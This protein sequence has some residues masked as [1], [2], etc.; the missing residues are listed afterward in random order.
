[1]LNRAFRSLRFAGLFAL[2]QVPIPPLP[3]GNVPALT[4]GNPADI[5][6]TVAPQD[7]RTA[8]QLGEPVRLQ[9]RFRANAAGRY[10]FAPVSCVRPAHSPYLPIYDR[11][12]AEPSGAAE[13]LAAPDFRE[14]RSGVRTLPPEPIP[15][16][17]ETVTAECLLNDWAL[18]QK[19]GHFRITAESVRVLAVGAPP[20]IAMPLKSEA[21]E[22][23]ILPLD[24]NAARTRLQQA[25]AVLERQYSGASVEN[26]EWA[27]AVDIV[28]FSQLPEAVPVLV[29]L[30]NQ[31]ADQTVINGLWVSPYKAAIF[32]EMEKNFEAP[33]FAVSSRWVFLMAQLDGALQN[34]PAPQD[35]LKELY[36][37][38]FGKLAAIV[39]RKQGPARLASL[40]TLISEGPVY[41][42][43]VATQPFLNTIYQTFPGLPP[44]FQ[45]M[46]LT[47]R[48]SFVAS[49][50]IAPFV[51]SW[52]TSNIAARDLA[53]LRLQ[54]LDPAEAR[55]IALDRIRRGD[56]VRNVS[57]GPR[58]YGTE[59]L[60]GL[61][62]TALPELDAPLA[63]AY[64]SG[65]PVAEL[66]ARYASAAV[67]PR[68]RAAFERGPAGPWQ[69]CGVNTGL[70]PIMVYFFRVDPTYADR[71][72]AE[73]RRSAPWPCP[74][75]S[76]MVASAGLEQAA[77]RDLSDPDESLRQGA[78]AVLRNSS[79]GNGKRALREA[80]GRSASLPSENGKLHP[81]S[82][83]A[84]ALTS[85]SGW[86][87]SPE[88]FG[89]LLAMCSRDECR[90]IISGRRQMVTAPVQIEARI[91]DLETI[92]VG[93]FPISMNNFERKLRQF[94][95]GTEFRLS[96]E[97]RQASALWSGDLW[98][99]RLRQ[100]IEAAGMKVVQEP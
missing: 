1:M 40:A 90:Q 61:S 50:A 74:L 46:I 29:R 15:L 89:Q 37:K 17:T 39:D 62:D 12:L 5:T 95:A 54:V 75:T 76:P 47:D 88:E 63:E 73:A 81:S 64:E 70:E 55:R 23:D 60:M 58:Q 36:G 28:R 4:F 84:D 56:F 80:L 48:W 96:P 98:E 66:I 99:K 71:L 21:L 14:S 85:A 77:I 87:L 79:A 52:A 9:L 100:T 97:A 10:R 8:F 16:G 11:I 86:V 24:T 18:I 27:A 65:K 59:A 43:L 72:L 68:I 32:A 45:T 94:P 44:W 38:Y 35:R 78:V 49:P 33:D 20:G 31:R 30:L 42:G 6:F 57:A 2:F 67:F 83:L 69:V 92:R 19:P 82:I 7:G 22:I 53:L 91:E 26:S 3:S 41:G 51:R 34:P 93:P 25:A 13:D